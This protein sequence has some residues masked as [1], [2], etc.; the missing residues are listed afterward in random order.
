MYLSFRSVFAVLAF[1]N[2]RKDGYQLGMMMFDELKE[3]NLRP[4]PFQFYTAKDLWTDEHTSREMLEYHLDEAVDL[5]S[6]NKDFIDR[7][8][9]WIVS[10]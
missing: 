2:Q 10:H 3:I 4:E 6:R 7:S 8:Y 5:S 9:L 1:I